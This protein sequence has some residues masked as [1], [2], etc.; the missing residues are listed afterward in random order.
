MMHLQE[1]TMEEQEQLIHFMTTN[2]WPY[3]G[4]SDPGRHLIEKAIEEGG[5]GS[6]EGK[7][8]WVEN[9]D[10][11]KVGIWKIYDL[12]DAIPLFDLR[13]ADMSRGNGYG[14]KALGLVAEYVFGLYSN[15]IRLEG[16]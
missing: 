15:K 5:Y 4:N 3:H 13:L 8:F 11:V 16:H 1:W 6:D 7:T 12:Q 2:T 9:N 10:E 14:P